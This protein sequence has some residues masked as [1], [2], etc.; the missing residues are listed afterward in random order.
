LSHKR[1]YLY[2]QKEL[3]FCYR[4]HS[5]CIWRASIHPGE[6]LWLRAEFL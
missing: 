4:C 2:G 1:V 6:R 5:R 3:N